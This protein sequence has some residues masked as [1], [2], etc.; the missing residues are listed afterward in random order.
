MMV[1]K[2]QQ[3]HPETHKGL[4]TFAGYFFLAG[5]LLFLTV[6]LLPSDP[7]FQGAYYTWDKSKDC[8]LWY[9]ILI[10]YKP[11]TRFLLAVFCYSLIRLLWQ[12]TTDLTDE[13][14][15]NPKWVTITW[16]ILVGFFVYRGTKELISEWKQRD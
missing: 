9:C 15:N 3:N 13:N 10:L 11:L 16:L 12:I 1:A 5:M 6:K 8:V 7:L 14:I 4:I 2:L